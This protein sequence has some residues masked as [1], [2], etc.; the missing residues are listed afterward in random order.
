MNLKEKN[1]LIDLF[2]NKKLKELRMEIIS[3]NEADI[4]EFLEE[5]NPIHS[6]AI[7]RLLPKDLAAEVFSFLDLQS[8]KNLINDMSNSELTEVVDRLYIDDMIDMLEELPASVIKKVMLGV[9]KEKRSIINE[10]L[11]YPE[12]SAGSIMTAEYIDAKKHNTVGQVLQKIRRKS[13]HMESIYTVYITDEKRKLEGFVSVR[14]ILVNDNDVLIRDLL[15]EDVIYSSTTD[16]REDVARLF[17]KYGFLAI[18]VVDNEKRLVGIVTFDD[19]IDVIQE[20]TTEDFE[21]MAAINPSERPYL[22]SNIFELAKNRFLWLI[23]LLLTAT[24]TGAI[25]NKFE[26]V[27]IKVSGIIAFLP[28]ITG[29]GGNS[30]S[31]SSTMIIR[32]LAVGEIDISDYIKVFLKEL[33][34]SV[35]VGFGLAVVNFIRMFIFRESVSVSLTVS[36]ALMFTII[37]AKSIGGLLPIIAKKLNM[38][39]AVMAA[40]LIT[41]VVDTLSLLIYVFFVELILI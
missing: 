37:I 19:I 7:F 30:G 8:Q 26:S 20:E 16:D 3:F 10:Y 25:I 4:A 5:I 32:G 17:T 38:D 29:A 28:M 27:L 1:L 12:D 18:P 36:L 9:N 14:T 39:P 2:N 6:L 41:T 33:G 15:E 13:Q 35:I 11:Q 21:K 34:V 24:I 40:P 31:Q 23:I 22:K